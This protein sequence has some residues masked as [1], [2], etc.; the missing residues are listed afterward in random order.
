MCV[1][2]KPKVKVIYAAG[3]WLIIAWRIVSK[4]DAECRSGIIAPDR[5][6]ARW[7]RP[8]YVAT[9]VWSETTRGDTR[10]AW[11]KCRHVKHIIVL[12]SRIPR[13]V[14]VYNICIQ[15]KNLRASRFWNFAHHC[16]TQCVEG[17]YNMSQ[18]NKRAVLNQWELRE[19]TGQKWDKNSSKPSTAHWRCFTVERWQGVFS[20]WKPYFSI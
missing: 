6:W 16:A 20:K 19:H 3:I 15:N 2:H 5:L 13:F 1:P 4:D 7:G 10:V 8:V 14:K 17:C 18:Y 11:E 9:A 12:V